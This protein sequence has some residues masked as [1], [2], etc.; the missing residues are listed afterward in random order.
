[1]KYYYRG[2]LGSKKK[3]INHISNY[4]S[5]YFTDRMLILTDYNSTPHYQ[6]K[7]YFKTDTFNS[8][9]NINKF[10]NCISVNSRIAVRYIDR[11]LMLTVT[12]HSCNT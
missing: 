1:M 7:I 9:K 4:V 10:S 2:C 11:M 8:I 6:I 12:L 5:K 3:T